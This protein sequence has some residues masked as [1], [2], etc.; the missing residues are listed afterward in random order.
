MGSPDIIPQGLSL[1]TRH[2]FYDGIIEGQKKEALIG[3]FRLLALEAGLLIGSAMPD[4]IDSWLT[5]L[6]NTSKDPHAL[7]IQHL[8]TASIEHLKEHR[9]YHLSIGDEPKAKWCESLTSRFENLRTKFFEP[10]HGSESFSAIAGTSEVERRKLERGQRLI[11]AQ[12]R[13]QPIAK[14]QVP[15]RW[16]HEAAGV[17]HKDAVGW[18]NGRLPD[19]SAVATRIEDGLRS[20]TPPKQP[21]RQRPNRRG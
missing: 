4:A 1:E 5:R 2:L 18:R 9:L 21:N 10:S 6:R 8:L 3:E 20:P 17:D 12:Q 13:W 19:T 16:V 14:L 15:F 11:A 7:V